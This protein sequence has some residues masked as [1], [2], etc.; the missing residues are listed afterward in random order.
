LPF[1][2]HGKIDRAALPDPN[3]ENIMDGNAFEAPQSEIEQWL[4]RFLTTLLGVG[5]VSRD[6]NFFSLGG[7]SLMGAQLIARVHQSF[8]V[9]LSLRSLF[10]HPTLR[11]ISA[12]IENLVHAKLNAMSDDEAR[13]VLESSSP[14]IPA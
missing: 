9:N 3:A 5:R 14:G 13:R 7:H 2:A 4:A 11:E 6:D 1:T 8:G 10:D 12:E